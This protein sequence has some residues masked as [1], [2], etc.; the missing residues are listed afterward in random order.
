MTAILVNG[1]TAAAIAISDRGLAY[2]DG[3]FETLAVVDGE[4]LGLDRHL[5]RME[6]GCARLGFAAPIDDVRRETHDMVRHCARAVL[7]VIVTRGAGGR[8]YQPPESCRPNRILSLQDWP[9]H[10]PDLQRDGIAVDYCSLRLAAQPALAGI[11][12]LNRLEQVLA[13]AETAR[14]G[15]VEGLMQDDRGCVVEGTMSNLFLLHGGELISPD[16]A[17]CGV[18]GIV[19]ELV[20]E[21]SHSMELVP[22]VRDVRPAELQSADEAFLCNSIIGIWPLRKIAGHAL[23]VGERTRAIAARLVKQRCIAPS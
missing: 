1:E 17:R 2:G 20:L 14:A 7:K 16:I 11:K 18:A 21:H 23:P 9:Q 13:R 4:A 8:G 15:H 19:R 5:R 22:V 10:A 3:V 12:H 6:Q